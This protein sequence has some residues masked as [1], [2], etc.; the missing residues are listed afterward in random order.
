[1][2]PKPKGLKA[3][4]RALPFDPAS[5]SS[6][7]TTASTSASSSA[8]TTERTFPLDED[9]LTLTD[10]FE[11]RLSVIE[12]LYPFPTDLDLSNVDRDKID[13]ARSLL[14]GILHGCAVL[15]Q[16]VLKS[17][18]SSERR[19]EVQQR[20]DEAGSD[21]LGAL[22][23]VDSPLT[24][25]LVLYLQAWSLQHLGQLFE[26]PKRDVRVAALAVKLQQGHKKRKVD[27][28]EPRT[29][30]EWFE[31]SKVKYDAALQLLRATRIE[32][33][34]EAALV[35]TLVRSDAVRCD[36]S[37][38]EGQS[39]DDNSAEASDL[40]SLVEDGLNR[41]EQENPVGVVGIETD[42]FEDVDA[43]LAQFRS[44]AAVID[45]I[46][47]QCQSLNHEDPKATVQPRKLLARMVRL[48]ED[49]CIDENLDKIDQGRAESQQVKAL[50]GWYKQ[51][52][53]ADVKMVEFVLLEDAIEAKYR[54]EDENDDEEEEEEDAEVKELPM[55]AEDVKIAK[56]AG[57]TAVQALRRTI[58]MFASLPSS[59]AHPAG[60]DAQYRKLEEV[61]LISSALVNPSDES[62]TKQIE[63]EIEAVRAEGGLEQANN[64]HDDEE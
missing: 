53:V 30:L 35:S 58:E 29:K 41:D 43:V 8:S 32:P 63:D 7:S 60:K 11:L 49:K 37:L 47:S 51:V 4:K 38:N 1:M 25:Q 56:E 20:R 62:G 59:V 44:W 45:S 55:D 10:L 27:L 48:L 14:R 26:D 23:L 15:E 21:K 17:Q 19:T 16:Y 5:I 18:G 22:G 52:L 12:I 24:E 2:P 61:L 42:C 36:L 28:H 39:H 57:T 6:E 64:E 9:C 46:E 33:G 40:W 54:P 13:E 34:T 3:S 31:M 50:F